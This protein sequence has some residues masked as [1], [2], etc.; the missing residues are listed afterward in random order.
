VTLFLITP[1]APVMLI[2]GLLLSAFF[3][4]LGTFFLSVICLRTMFADRRELTNFVRANGTFR[5]ILFGSEPKERAEP[6]SATKGIAL[7]VLPDGEVVWTSQQRP[8]NASMMLYR[9][10]R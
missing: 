8:S 1:D 5:D 3:V 10:R 6:G 2:P 4:V 9:N 7:K